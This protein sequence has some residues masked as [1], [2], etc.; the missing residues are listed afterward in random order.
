MESKF[1]IL[2]LWAN[3]T[4]PPK[5]KNI[6]KSRKTDPME[7]K[8]MVKI[9]SLAENNAL[10]LEQLLQYRLTDVCLPILNINGEIKKAVMEE[11]IVNFWQVA[12]VE[13]R[14]LWRKCI[15]N[16][17]DM[18]QVA[19]KFTWGDYARKIFTKILQRHPNTKEFHLVNY[20]F[21]MDL[22][23][24]DAEHK[25]RSALFS[26]GSKNVFS[27]SIYTVPLARKFSS[28][29]ANSENKITLHEFLLK[30][31]PRSTRKISTVYS[32]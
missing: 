7:N 2:F 28:F 21:D 6:E 31:L 10:D 27:S 25:K 16:A 17:A 22:S 1:L 29:F 30:I 26:G 13:M 14:F 11:I 8:A 9:F 15:Q 32:R 5:E 20:R 19:N 18:D 12:T 3:F 24:K 23:I 4:K